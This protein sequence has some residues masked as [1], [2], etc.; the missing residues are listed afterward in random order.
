MC[1]MVEKIIQIEILLVKPSGIS[2]SDN[3]INFANHGFSNGD[4]INYSTLAGLG[5][6]TPQTISGLSTSLSYYILKDDDNSIQISKCRYWWDNY[7]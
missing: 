7:N 3:K 6:D 5:S 1:L 4:L 2:T